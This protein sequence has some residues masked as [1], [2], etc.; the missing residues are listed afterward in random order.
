VVFK[1]DLGVT[2]FKPNLTVYV[3]DL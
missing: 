2:T 1:L 3:L